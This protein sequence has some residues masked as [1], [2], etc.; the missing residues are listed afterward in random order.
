MFWRV[1]NRG[2]T[3]ECRIAD[4]F[5]LGSAMAFHV[6]ARLVAGVAAVATTAGA[7]RIIAADL[8]GDYNVEVVVNEASYTGTAKTTPAGK[9]GFTAK[10]DFTSP[11]PVSADATG[12]TFGDSVTFDAK[13]VDNTRNCTGTLTAKGTVEKDGNKAA[14]TVAINDSCDGEA[15]GTFRLY[16]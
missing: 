11:G 15:S 9:G 1:C 5:N 16:R 6:I 3:I 12:K 8:K 10:L 4:F 13:Y 14:G 2:D 7:V